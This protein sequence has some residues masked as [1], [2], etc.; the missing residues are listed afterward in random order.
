L[1]QATT[2]INYDLPWKY[3]TLL[4]RV[5]RIN[6]ITSE[7][8]HVWYFNLIVAKSME[9]RKMEI[10]ERKRI[11][12]EAIADPSIEHA[13]AISTLTLAD[14]KYILNGDCGE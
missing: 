7:A 13:E 4:Q 3:S 9:E 14:Y 1:E 5:N 6:R 8:E 11:M 10:L 2:V 12:H